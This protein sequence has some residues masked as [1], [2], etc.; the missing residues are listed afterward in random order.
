M[1][2]ESKKNKGIKKKGTYTQMNKK[3]E[4][5]FVN[6]KLMNAFNKLKKGTFEDKQLLRLINRAIDDLKENPWFSHKIYERR[7]KY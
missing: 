3:K 2:L 5:A 7:F 4:V 1:D 6:E